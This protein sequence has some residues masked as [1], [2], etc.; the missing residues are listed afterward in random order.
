MQK[1]LDKKERCQTTGAGQATLCATCV[2]Y[3]C[4]EVDKECKSQTQYMIRVQ[5]QQEHQEQS[6]SA[7]HCQI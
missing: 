5:V 6:P 1:A 4:R 7:D 2:P 3:V